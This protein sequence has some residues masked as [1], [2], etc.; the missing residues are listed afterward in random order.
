MSDAS[1]NSHLF[2]PSN[3]L[4]ES[5][6]PPSKIAI[7]NPHFR[8]PAAQ[9]VSIAN[10]RRLLRVTFA[11]GQSCN[12]GADR[13]RMHCRCA[14]CSRA[15]IDGTF[16]PLAEEIEIE[17]ATPIGQYGVN[18]AFSDGHARGIFPFAYLAELAVFEAAPEQALTASAGNGR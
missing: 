4:R 12:V 11:D 8:D 1:W 13:L 15:R 3:K 7:M 14:T 18:L 16:A 6:N 10:R 9:S 17:Q 2:G 5:A